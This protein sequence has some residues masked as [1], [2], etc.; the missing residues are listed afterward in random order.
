MSFI[1]KW[2]KIIV[3]SFSALA[4]ALLLA[5]FVRLEPGHAS[6]VLGVEIESPRETKLMDDIVREQRQVFKNFDS[7]FDKEFFQR[8]DPFSDMRLFRDRFWD[9][10]NDPLQS[11]FVFSNPF[12]TWYEGRFGG[13][14]DDIAK[15]EEENAVVYE[16]RVPD[17]VSTSVQVSASDG[18]V[19]ITGQT[20]KPLLDGEA[21]SSFKRV[22]PVPE[23]VDESRVE[24][25]HEKNKV[26]LKFPKG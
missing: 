12:D 20:M 11:P 18:K 17:V 15:R 14:V 1:R 24:I 21:T 6:K 2:K 26:I 4:G 9:R 25:Q 7:L 10:L 19:T 3:P 16:V 13:L 8:K 23:N 22:F 5:L